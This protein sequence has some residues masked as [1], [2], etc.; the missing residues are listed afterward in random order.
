VKRAAFSS[1]S[2]IHS[3]GYTL[4]VTQRQ[5]SVLGSYALL[6]P[7]CPSSLTKVDLT[8]DSTITIDSANLYEHNAKVEK[9]TVGKVVVVDE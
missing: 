8:I 5:L 1:R 6:L 9:G 2:K 4:V 3:E 7:S